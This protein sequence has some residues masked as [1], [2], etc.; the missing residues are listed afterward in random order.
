M[1]LPF[2]KGAFVLAIAAGLPVVPVTMRGTRRLMPRGSRMT[3][4]PG[5]V[6]IVIDEPIPTSG[7]GYDDR[8]ALA[9]RVRT[10]IERHHTGW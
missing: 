7:L 3:V 4:V 9:A 2:K 5:D 1:R 8:E 6:E 10:A